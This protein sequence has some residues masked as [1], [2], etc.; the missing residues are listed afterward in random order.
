MQI[1]KKCTQVVTNL[2]QSKVLKKPKIYFWLLDQFISLSSIQR[3]VI[4]K[5]LD[6]KAFYFFTNYGQFSMNL[7]ASLFIP[8]KIP[9]VQYKGETA[10]TNTQKHNKDNQYCQR[11]GQRKKPKRRN[12]FH[13]DQQ[14]VLQIPITEGKQVAHFFLSSHPI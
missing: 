7:H 11:K 8:R 3:N 13:S 6:T 1:R 10:V 12:L 5:K 14:N 9:I 4:C 2:R